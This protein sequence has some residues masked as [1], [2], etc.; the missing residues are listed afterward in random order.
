MAFTMIILM[1]IYTMKRNCGNSMKLIETIMLS[2]ITMDFIN[3]SNPLVS[4]HCYITYRFKSATKS[5]NTKSTT[6][7]FL[8]LRYREMEKPIIITTKSKIN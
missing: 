3:F 5:R 6:N 4:V 1:E 8:L 2:I 7:I